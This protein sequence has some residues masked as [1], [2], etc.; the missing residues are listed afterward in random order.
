MP[1][2]F[3][4]FWKSLIWTTYAQYT[5]YNLKPHYHDRTPLIPYRSYRPRIQSH[6]ASERRRANV[7]RSQDQAPQS[8]GQVGL[9][10]LLPRLLCLYVHGP[11]PRYMR[12]Y[13]IDL[14]V[15]WLC[16]MWTSI[17]DRI[18]S[19]WIELDSIGSVQVESNP[20]G[21]AMLSVSSLSC[22]CSW[23]CSFPFPFPFL[24]LFPFLFLFTLTF[25]S[26]PFQILGVVACSIFY[27]FT[28]SLSLYLFCTPP[29]QCWENQLFNNTLNY[30]FRLFS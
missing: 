7:S 14:I 16:G 10:A 2:K 23:S 12:Q 4:G 29:S 18:A 5:Y 6:R 20:I 26:V 24:N 28:L 15:K 1:S 22:C 19:D 17:P 3:T 21:S 13:L 9:P 8:A 30:Y 25:H 11:R 27:S